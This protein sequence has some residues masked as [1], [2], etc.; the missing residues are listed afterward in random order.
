MDRIS[1]V[2][3]FVG[4]FF[5]FFIFGYVVGRGARI[6]LDPAV[7]IERTRFFHLYFI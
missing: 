7:T 6:A 1:R 3:L 2:T 5:F 4:F